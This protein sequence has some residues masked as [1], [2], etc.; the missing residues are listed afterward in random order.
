MSPIIVPELSQLHLNV[1]QL[2]ILSGLLAYTPLVQHIYL[3]LLYTS[4]PSLDT[5]AIA[6]NSLSPSDMAF[7]KAVLSAH[8]VAPKEEFSTFTPVNTCLLYTSRCV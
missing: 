2:Y 8:I 3:C 5:T 7:T 4:S 6:S 1:A